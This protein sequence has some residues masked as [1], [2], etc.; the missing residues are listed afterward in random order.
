LIKSTVVNVVKNI[1][2]LTKNEILCAVED[3]KAKKLIEKTQ[4]SKRTERI[5][6]KAKLKKFYPDVW[7]ALKEGDVLVKV[8]RRCD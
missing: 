2:Y 4:S 1:A 3:Y 5:L 6:A 8:K 7:E